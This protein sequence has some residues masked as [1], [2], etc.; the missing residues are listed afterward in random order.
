MDLG[1]SS[2]LTTIFWQLFDPLRCHKLSEI[3]RLTLLLN[4]SQINGVL[5]DFVETYRD[6][7]VIVDPE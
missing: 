4:A 5:I 2:C 1:S 3:M 7:V 6:L